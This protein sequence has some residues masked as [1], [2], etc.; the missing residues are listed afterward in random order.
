MIRFLFIIFFLGNAMLFAQEYER[1]D[2]TIQ[3]Y[4]E[5]FESPEAFSYLISRDFTSE[6]DKVRAIY[7]WLIE[8]VAYDPEE[9]KKFNYSFKNYRERN[10]KE[11]K[12]RKKIIE[13]TLKTGKA[14]C[15]GYA[16][17]FEKMCQL[18][19]IDSY[20]VRGDTKT[21]FQDIGR[22]FKKSHLWNAVKVAGEWQLFDAT[23][24][25]GTYR[26]KFIKEPTYYYFNIAPK[27][28]IKSHYPSMKED[29]FMDNPVD[30][31]NFSK[32][33]LILLPGLLSEQLV[34]PKRG[35]INSK[36]SD[37]TIYFEIIMK[38]PQHIHYAYGSDKREVLFEVKEK[39]LHFSV[40]VQ[41]GHDTLLIYFD[42][43]PILGYK[44]I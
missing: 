6:A 25:A 37:N 31:T 29:Q 5:T 26:G 34:A 27:E 35:I 44:V 11:E 18:Q 39:V 14:V 1:V 3:L 21:H 4:P 30:H 32:A 12:T 16:F 15:E 41:M 2:A 10:A 28:C 40:P 7:G 23:W 20:L 22:A 33:P 24:G 8:N 9:Y 43:K 17:V 19:G 42:E 13:R 36:S 38:A